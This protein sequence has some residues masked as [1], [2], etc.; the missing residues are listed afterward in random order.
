MELVN[1]RAVWKFQKKNLEAVVQK[2]QKLQ[3]GKFDGVLF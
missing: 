1:F 2:S 3:E